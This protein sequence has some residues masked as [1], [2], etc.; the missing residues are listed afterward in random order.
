MTL[1]AAF[2]VLLFRYRSGGV[3]V[4]SPIANR[5]HRQTEERRVL[6]QHFGVAFA[7]GARAAVHR[8]ARRAARDALDAYAHQDLP[9]ETL[10]DDLAPQC[11]PSQPVVPPCSTKTP[12]ETV[13]LAMWAEPLTFD[14]DTAKFDPL[15]NWSQ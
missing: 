1:L 2:K 7:V 13:E 9:F 3:L 8:V 15:V 5:T 4:C 11:S 12:F 6:R 10:V 14:T